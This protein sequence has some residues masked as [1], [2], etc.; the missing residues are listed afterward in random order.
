MKEEQEQEE[1]EGKKHLQSPSCLHIRQSSGKRTLSV[2]NSRGIVNIGPFAPHY[3][4]LYRMND[5][6]LL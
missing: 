4:H 6:L 5:R 2:L 1:E 3:R